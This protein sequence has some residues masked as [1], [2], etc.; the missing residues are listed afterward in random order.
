VIVGISDT[1]WGV[2]LPH[3]HRIALEALGQ[4]DLDVELERDPVRVAEG[5]ER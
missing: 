3:D 1:L 5:E 2:R 4:A